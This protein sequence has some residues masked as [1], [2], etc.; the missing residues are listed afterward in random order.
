MNENL[1]YKL[2]KKINQN[3]Q[4]N[5]RQWLYFNNNQKKLK[6]TKNS[7]KKSNNNYN[8][9]IAIHS[10]LIKNKIEN[11]GPL[12]KNKLRFNHHKSSSLQKIWQNKKKNLFN[13]LYR[14]ELKH[15]KLK[16]SFNLIKI[17]LQNT[18]S[19]NKLL[20]FINLIK[21]TLK[22]QPI[23]LSWNRTIFLLLPLSKEQQYFKGIKIFYKNQ[24]KKE[25]NI[26]E[27]KNTLLLKSKTL[28]KTKFYYKTLKI[29]LKNKVPKWRQS[30]I[31]FWIYKQTRIKKKRKLKKNATN[32]KIL[33]K[34][35]K[36][37]G[38]KNKRAE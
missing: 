36:N 17:Y 8:N 32:Y 10:T 19:F 16:F 2:K 1:S 14:T 21:I 13:Q 3:T 20:K 6:K 34:Q 38:E 11:I 28:S 33:T 15:G 18:I 27:L 7:K 30:K 22:L 25:D 9:K 4:N 12:L 23:T 35:I 24:S 26:E 5:S 29:H 37:W 31:P